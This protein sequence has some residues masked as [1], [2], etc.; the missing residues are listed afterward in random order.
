MSSMEDFRAL[1]AKVRNWGRWGDD[2]QLGTLNFIDAAARV[3]AAACVQDGKAFSL[4]IPLSVDG[5]Q[6]G[7]IPGRENPV[8]DVFSIDEENITPPG[9]G[10]S[11]DSITMGTATPSS[12]R[13]RTTSHP[14]MSGI[15]TSISISAGRN[16]CT[17]ARHAAPCGAS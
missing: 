8:L 13:R 10:F 9:F 5:P 7:I 3:R 2:D 12:R 15:E 6:V 14:V 17:Q 16:V 4:A 1:A 11:D